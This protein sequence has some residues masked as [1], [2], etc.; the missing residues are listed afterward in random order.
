MPA[1][2]LLP[3][4][5]PA[6]S[7]D[8]PPHQIDRERL[9][10]QLIYLRSKMIE[11]ADQ[12]GA[13]IVKDASDLIDQQSELVASLKGLVNKQQMEMASYL[14]IAAMRPGPSLPG[15]APSDPEPLPWKEN[16]APRSR[17][18]LEVVVSQQT[19]MRALVRHYGWTHHGA[20]I[21]FRPDKPGGHVVTSPAGAPVDDS[22]IDLVEV[23]GSIADHAAAAAASVA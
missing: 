4:E 17:S 20:N 9:D 10:A 12:Y 19:A 2:P 14:S 6:P 15:E 8:A 3:G 13:L 18:P 7:S 16:P 11:E 23:P 21:L 1:C 22:V 5:P